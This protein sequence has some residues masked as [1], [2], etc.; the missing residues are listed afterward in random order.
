LGYD[1]EFIRAMTLVVH[2]LRSNPDMK[3]KLLNKPDAI[4]AACPHNS[5]GVCAN[6]EIGSEEHVA[7]KDLDVLERLGLK[8][9]EVVTMNEIL[10]SVRD[11]IEVGYLAII[12]RD[13]PWL[14][15]GYCA[16]GI[17]R[18]KTENPW[19]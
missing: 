3:V 11:K 2:T 5:N 9:G 18:V 13:C 10:S 12:C 14:D 16:E 1:E 8:V 15:L 7:L 19:R 17:R 4:C 6:E